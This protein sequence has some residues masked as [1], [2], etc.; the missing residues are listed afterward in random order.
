MVDQVI[1]VNLPRKLVTLPVELTFYNA[2]NGE[3]LD[4]DNTILTHTVGD[5]LSYPTSN[6][7]D[8]LIASGGGQGIKSTNMLTVGQGSGSTSIDMSVTNA[9]GSGFAFDFS[10]TIEAEAG[11]GGWTVGGSSGFHY[12]ESYNITTSDGMLY[13]GEVSNI[14]AEDYNLNRAFSW[15]LFSYKAT[16][17][18]EKFLIV[19]YYTEGI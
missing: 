19:Q 17:G 3:A 12:G 18:S 9:N 15:G 14:A 4:I 5:P 16:L 2:N 7:A 11:A 6:E 10:V 8:E 1:T 13:G